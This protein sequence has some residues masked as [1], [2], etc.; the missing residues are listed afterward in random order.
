MMP[1]DSFAAWVRITLNVSL[2]LP[3]PVGDFYS[4]TSNDARSAV[5]CGG[6]DNELEEQDGHSACRVVLGF[7]CA[8][9]FTAI[10]GYLDGGCAW[11]E[12]D[13]RSVVVTLSITH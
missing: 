12:V 9:N 7:V 13:P 8:L 10:Q 5:E 11:L 2:P 3:P 1:C 6:A 4:Y